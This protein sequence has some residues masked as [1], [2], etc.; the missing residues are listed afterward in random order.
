MQPFCTYFVVVLRSP[1]QDSVSQLPRTSPC[2]VIFAQMRFHEQLW[3]MWGIALVCTLLAMKRKLIPELQAIRKVAYSIFYSISY[4]Y[5]LKLHGVRQR[6]FTSKNS[7]LYSF[8]HARLSTFTFY[9][10]TYSCSLHLDSHT[11]TSKLK[12]ILKESSRENHAVVHE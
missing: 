2:S 10:F 4:H 5:V 11:N 9:Q 1:S 8:T 3:R 6:D 12:R 7:I